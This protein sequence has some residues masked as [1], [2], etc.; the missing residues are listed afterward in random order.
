MN[1]KVKT[2]KFVLHAHLANERIT[3]GWSYYISPY[4]SMFYYISIPEIL[5]A[6]IFPKLF[7]SSILLGVISY[8]VLLLLSYHMGIRHEKFKKEY[9]KMNR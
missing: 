1:K 5:I 2:E 3:N 4:F 8:I 6:K 7:T 9:Y